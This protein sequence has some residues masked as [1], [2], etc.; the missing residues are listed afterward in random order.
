MSSKTFSIV[1]TGAGLLVTAL[2]MPIYAAGTIQ[3]GTLETGALPQPYSISPAQFIGDYSPT[4]VLDSHQISV[5]G[6]WIWQP[7]NT[8]HPVSSATPVAMKR[9]YYVYAPSNYHPGTAAPLVILLHGG[10]LDFTAPLK[11]SCHTAA[12]KSAHSGGEAYGS[13]Q[14]TWVNSSPNPNAPWQG[15]WNPSAPT[16]VDASGFN[17]ATMVKSLAD[18]YPNGILVAIP[19][20]ANDGLINP[21]AAGGNY[22]GSGNGVGGDR[23]NDCTGNYQGP[24]QNIGSWLFPNWIPV[25]TVDDVAF[26]TQMIQKMRAATANGGD[27]YSIDTSRVY[28]V[29]ASNGGSMAN[30]L[31]REMPG[32]AAAAFSLANDGATASTVNNHTQLTLRDTCAAT[33]SHQSNPVPVWMYKGEYDRDTVY[34]G[35]VTSLGTGGWYI[36]YEPYVAG[37]PTW[38][39]TA[40]CAVGAYPSADGCN[41]ATTGNVTFLSQILG[42]YGLTGSPTTRTLSTNPRPADPTPASI[43]NTDPSKQIKYTETSDA[44]GPVADANGN[45]PQTDS[46]ISCDLYGSMQSRTQVNNC[47]ATYGGHQ[48][49]SWAIPS[50]RNTMAVLGAQNLDIDTA[51]QEWSFL[52]HFNLTGYVP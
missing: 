3:S 22:D 20:G 8:I 45:Y 7:G 10:G 30:R 12:C 13:T 40:G 21:D 39:N 28:V 25:A 24:Y 41:M 29:G 2:S 5:T 26:M 51:T 52:V 42:R 35:G 33:V 11:P 14:S 50:S 36:P 6:G 23:W 43:Y 19:N 48:E 47:V 15:V 34:H 46:T 1:S 16:T 38:S 49:A 9:Y 18:Q 32:V 31:A 37:H 44:T 27:G 4:G 17:T